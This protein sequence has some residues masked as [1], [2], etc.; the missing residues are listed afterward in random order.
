MGSAD[1]HGSWDGV[2]RHDDEPCRVWLASDGV[3]RALGVRL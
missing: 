3:R 1:E 2:F